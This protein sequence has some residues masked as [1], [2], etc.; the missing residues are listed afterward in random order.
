MT[1]L[2]V[3]MLLLEEGDK[4]FEVN[5]SFGI[6]DEQQIALQD[7]CNEESMYQ[8]LYRVVMVHDKPVEGNAKDAKQP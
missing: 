7:D 5:R 6:V 2:Y 4:C 3:S 1:K 8:K